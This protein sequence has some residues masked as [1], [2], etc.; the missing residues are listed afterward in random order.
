M[1]LTHL[2][3][4]PATRAGI[5]AAVEDAQRRMDRLTPSQ[6]R[7]VELMIDGH[8]NRVIAHKLGISQRTVENHRA[9]IMLRLGATTMADVTRIILLAG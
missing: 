1:R 3:T 2:F 4:D 7:I 8:L 6:R 9:E 5:N